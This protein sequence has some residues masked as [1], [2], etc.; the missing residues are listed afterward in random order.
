MPH[1]VV[2]SRPLGWSGRE[3]MVKNPSP[4]R[5]LPLNMQPSPGFLPS[6]AKKALGVEQRDILPAKTMCPLL[7]SHRLLFMW[8]NI[9]YGDKKKK[10]ESWILNLVLAESFVDCTA[11]SL[12][13][14]NS[15]EHLGR[16]SKAK[17]EGEQQWNIIKNVACNYR[18]FNIT[19][20][21]IS[22]SGCLRA[23]TNHTV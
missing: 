15:A 4:P 10:K 16:R 18:Y 14:I 6:T 8:M 17:H 3:N 19:V 7:V 21:L 5:R 23:K 1:C 22:K 2:Y 9:T 11:A 20:R 12:H 13:K